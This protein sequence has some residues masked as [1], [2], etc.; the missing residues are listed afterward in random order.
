MLSLQTPVVIPLG[1]E[2]LLMYFVKTE[3]SML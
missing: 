2:H 1:L 3:N